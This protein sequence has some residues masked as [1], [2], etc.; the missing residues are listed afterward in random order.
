MAN[1]QALTLMT[2]Q[3]GAANGTAQK[4]AGGVGVF[5]A[6]GTWGGGT[7]KLQWSPDAGTT[8]MDVDRSG[9]SFVTL[10][11]NGAGEFTLPSCDIRAVTSGSITSVTA[12][13]RGAW[14]D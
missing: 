2:N 3:A 12:V 5:S 8:W 6:Y 14:K 13:A 10:T 9:D 4:W 11:A 7:C 1:N